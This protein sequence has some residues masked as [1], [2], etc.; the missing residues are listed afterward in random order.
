MSNRPLS[1]F[2]LIDPITPSQLTH[3][4]FHVNLP[5]MTPRLKAILTVSL[6]PCL[7]VFLTLPTLRA[8]AEDW[9][10]WRG[11][12][13]TAHVPA[14][15]AIPDKL[16]A[17]PKVLWH[18]PLG[19]GLASPVVAG[20]RVFYLDHQDGK[21]VVHGADAATGKEQWSAPLDEVH[22]DSQSTPG[23]RCTPSSDGQ[24]V[25]AQS[26]RGELQ[27]LNAA[28]GKV[29]WRTNY[30]KDF[31]A[32]FI[33]EKGTAEGASRHG[34]NGSPLIDGDHLIAEVGGKDADGKGGVVCFD[35]LTGKV[36]WKSPA[37]M[38]GYAA[39]VLTTIAGAPQV[40]CFMA[41]AVVGIGRSDGKLLWSFPVKTRLARHVTT[42]VIAG[43]LVLVASH[44]VGLLAVKVT[45]SPE[46]GDAGA[47]VVSTFQAEKAWLLKEAMIN[48][49][50]PVAEGGALYGVGPAKNLIC[51]DI[52]TGKQNW[53]KDGF[54]AGGAGSAWAGILVMGGNL[55]ILTDNGELVL[56]AADPK[57]YRELGR[58]QVAGTNWCIPAYAD[59]KL[60]LRDARELYCVQ[61][62]P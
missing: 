34:Y 37:M 33:G 4:P 41:D 13:R 20:G 6:S 42:P 57:Q 25:Y 61:L 47:A 10:Q 22:K 59:G 55:L 15:V 14:N 44:Q 2:P 36:I 60:Y 43:D 16:P 1:R 7:I 28:D 32:V 21:E 18:V 11:P 38:P 35:K 48:F 30:V 51:I 9:G 24:R 46:R 56:A 27:C 54:F 23:P 17:S 39:P 3:T 52:A 49:A 19:N 53:S 26:C 29:I 8:S 50:S 31:G 12:D 40:V 45:R 5:S 62:M 58:V